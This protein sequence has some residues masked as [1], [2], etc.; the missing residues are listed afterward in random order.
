MPV[1]QNDTASL[2]ISVL[3]VNEWEPRF[4]YPQ[5]EFRVEEAADSG[6]LLRV[7]KLDVHDGDK[8]DSVTLT[9]RGSDAG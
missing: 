7:G 3:N 1:P 9:L 2:N 5:Y 6:G 8:P 4:R